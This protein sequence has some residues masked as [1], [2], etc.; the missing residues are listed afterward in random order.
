N[1]GVPNPI[2]ILAYAWG[3]MVTDIIQPFWAIPLLGVARLEFRDILGYEILVLAL[4][5]TVM[6]A[7][8]LLL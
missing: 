8:L 5:A 2:T 3:D 4:Y 7:A 6:S 1:L